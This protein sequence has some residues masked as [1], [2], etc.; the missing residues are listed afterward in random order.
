MST[1]TEDPLLGGRGD[2]PDVQV[3]LLVQ[4]DRRDLRVVE[5][6]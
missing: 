1:V 6:D 3:A 2:I 5:A 4:G